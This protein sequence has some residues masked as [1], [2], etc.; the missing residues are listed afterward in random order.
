MK[1]LRKL[2]TYILER[3]PIIWHSKVIY[4]LFAGILMWIGYFLI[5]YGITDIEFLKTEEIDEYFF[6]SATLGFHCFLTIILLTVWALYFFKK[7][8]IRHYYPLKRFYFS[9]LFIVIQLGM[10]PIVSVYLP[11]NYGIALKTKQL[12]SLN[13]LKVN[14]ETTNLAMAFLSEDHLYEIHN[15]DFCLSKPL[16]IIDFD[17]NDSTWTQTTNFLDR[18]SSYYDAKKYPERNIQLDGITIQVLSYHSVRKRNQCDSYDLDYVDSFLTKDS[19]FK[20]CSIYNYSKTC[21]SKSSYSGYNEY[22]DS[23]SAKEYRKDYLPLVHRWVKNNEKDSIKN[24]IQKFKIILNR[25]NI[26]CFIDQQYLVDYLSKKQYE[27]FP[28]ALIDYSLDHD[29]IK[30]ARRNFS[31]AKLNLDEYLYHQNTVEP[32]FGFGLY[33]LKHIQENA[34]I[35]FFQPINLTQNL[36]IP[37]MIVF[38]IGLFFLIFDFANFIQLVITIP[39]A[40]VLIIIVGL[41]ASLI[42]EYSYRSGYG[43]QSFDASLSTLFFIVSTVILLLAAFSVYR[44]FFSKRI[45]GILINLGYMV[46]PFFPGIVI[47]F[48]DQQTKARVYDFCNGEYVEHTFWSDLLIPEILFPLAFIASIS[49]FSLIKKWYAKPE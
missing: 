42:H 26:S 4:M 16:R 33:K 2:D 17:R 41:M 15:R 11:F 40:G 28:S 8:A 1:S 5:G 12:V 14:A 37:L 20:R 34:N 48:L 21:Y 45:A 3:Y 19:T 30:Y 10:L 25:Y 35:A 13:D 7:N 44:R 39:I 36:L 47:Y 22:G 49:Y 6:E 31:V 38:L 32:F 24:A 29:A 46:A 9:K 18:D 43:Y 27:N 23:Y